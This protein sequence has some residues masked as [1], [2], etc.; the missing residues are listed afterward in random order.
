DEELECWS[1]W[2][3]VGSMTYGDTTKE[4]F[5]EM[6]I[7]I[8]LDATGRLPLYLSAWY[9]ALKETIQ[10]T[11]KG[12]K[13]SFE[14]A[15]KVLQAQPAFEKMRDDIGNQFE[16]AKEKGKLSKFI[17]GITK[18]LFGLP[19]IKPLDDIDSRYFRIVNGVGEPSCGLVGSELVRQ[20]QKYN[21]NARFFDTTCLNT[22]K[23]EYGMHG[24]KF[25][26]IGGALVERAIIGI[27]VERPLVLPLGNMTRNICPTLLE[28]ESGSEQS[29]M[30]D[31][32]MEFVK[33]SKEEAL[34]MA[35]PLST[36]YKVVDA[37]MMGFRRESKGCHMYIGA[38]Q[39][40]IGKLPKHR[41]NRKVF[42]KKA[43]IKWV[44]PGLN[45]END[46]SWSMNWIL[47]EVEMPIH[48]GQSTKGHK[49][50][51]IKSKSY[52]GKSRMGKEVDCLE[53]FT[54]FHQI[55][56]RLSFLDGLKFHPSPKIDHTS[57]SY[58]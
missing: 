57:K 22:I 15:L 3:F 41:H 12:E 26:V 16:N 10:Q 37:V 1:K 55:D 11:T 24:R 14:S 31:L 43:C 42:M 7:Q 35:V 49:G 52:I 51:E 53:V 32:H 20:L 45:I 4:L 46:V 8:L 34:F 27:I 30:E 58:G 40:T 5:D 36:T 28:L 29:T 39:V 25:P 18:Y 56:S 2:K 33:G 48:I 23:R 13:V 54:T 17:D 21:Q 19:M 6:E 44:P 9:D 47:P 50:L 38:M